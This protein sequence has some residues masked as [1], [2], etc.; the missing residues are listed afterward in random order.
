MY[1]KENKGKLMTKKQKKEIPRAT[2]K[3]DE[4]LP[5]LKETTTTTNQ[6]QIKQ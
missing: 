3:N 4:T 1:K 6:Q 2:P 5:T